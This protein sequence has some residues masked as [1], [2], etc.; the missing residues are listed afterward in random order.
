MLLEAFLSHITHTLFY[1]EPGKPLQLI[2]IQPRNHSNKPSKFLTLSPRP[3]SLLM[4]SPSESQQILA[5]LDKVISKVERKQYVR[6]KS[7]LPL[8][9]STAEI[10][11]EEEIQRLN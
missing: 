11:A 8:L 10:P 2:K 3:L 5:L 6:F 9:I 7:R 4:V 1:A